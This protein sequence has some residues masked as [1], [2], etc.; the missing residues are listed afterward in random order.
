MFHNLKHYDTYLTMQELGKFEFKISFIPNGSEKYKSFSLDNKLVL[1]DGFQL[2]NFLL[3]SFFKNLGI[4]DFQY[5]S[6]EF[7]SEVLDLIKQKR[8]YR[9]EYMSDFEKIN[10]TLLSI[11]EFYSSL[12][13]KGISDKEY[14]HVLK[15]WNKFEMKTMKHYHNLYLKCNALLLTDVPEKI[16]NRCLENYGLYPSH[17]LS[18]PALSWDEMFSMTKA[19]RDLISDVDMYLCFEKGMRGYVSLISKRYNKA[20][21]KYLT[22]YDPKKLTKYIIHLDKNNFYDYAMSK[23]IP[24]ARFKWLN[25]AKF[26]L[27]NSLRDFVLE[28]EYP[29]F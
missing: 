12:S 23:S 13:G 4:N 5:L 18:A 29:I 25:A 28:V 19:K 1:I 16:R 21:D 22:T 15:V 2:L 6:Q 3:D 10:Q 14:Q 20:N 7:D 17:Y 11:N 24:K 26:N 27:H 8:F 9:Y